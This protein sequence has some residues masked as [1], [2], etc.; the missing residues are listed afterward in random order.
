MHVVVVLRLVPDLT[1]EIAIAEDGRSID[2]E[3]I[4]IRSNEF[5]DHA[6]EEAVLLK[7]ASGATITAIALEGDGADRLLHT[8]LAR[9]ADR[10]LK[11]KHGSD[12]VLSS[13]AAAPLFAAA[14]R[15]LGADLVFTGVQTPEDIFGQLAPYLGAYLQWPQISAVSG[16]RADG[17]GIELRQEFSGGVSTTLRVT[18]PAVA[19]IQTAS[20]PIRYVTGSKLRQAAGEKIATLDP[21]AEPA[22]DRAELVN[23]A[24]PETIGAAEMLGGD[25]KVV[26]A[27]V[28]ALLV[29]R[30]LAIE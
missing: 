2:R 16:V 24:V 18:L 26:A 10:A 30:G 6:L 22:P 25:A 1:G 28:R 21:E 4:D 27:R 20:Q 13:R 11:I 23:L 19:G 7:E 3:W 17:G 12:D 29:E 15:K 8:A 5:D 9:G 14:A